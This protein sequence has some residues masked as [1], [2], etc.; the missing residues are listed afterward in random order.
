MSNPRAILCGYYGQGNGGDEALLATLL[1]M[2]PAHV[3]PVV[4]SGDPE[5]TS[6]QYGVEAVSRKALP[7]VIQ[8]LQQAQV[9]VW[10]GGSLVQ[11]A[12]SALSPVYYTSLMA[13][14]QWMGKT[15]IAWA[16]GIGPLHR[17]TTRW[18]AHQTFTRCTAVSVRDQGS[19]K[20]MSAWQCPPLLAPDPVWALESLPMTGLSDLPAPRIAVVLRNHPDLTPARCDRLI[21][22]LVTL[23]QATDTCILLLPFQP[24]RDRALAETVQAQL[25][26]PNKLLIVEDPRKLKGVFRGVEMTIAMRFHG[27]IMAAAEGC[28]CFA[29]SYDPKVSQLMTALDLPGWTLGQ[30]PDDPKEIC[31]TWLEYYVNGTSLSP[32][33]VASLVDRAK[34]HQQLLIETIGSS[35]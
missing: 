33:Q 17:A 2:L 12:T 13:I 11:D 25:K 7:A 4:L 24:T 14:A 29:L 34:M 27:L 5:K 18:L 10:G 16:Q 19:A 21:Q 1:Q 35:T 23:Q 3:I 26:G 15:T 20:L 28:R 9:F 30:I 6:R 32:D 31:R 8:A 22:A